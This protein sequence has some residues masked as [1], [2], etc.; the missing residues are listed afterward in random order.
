[1]VQLLYGLNDGEID[2]YI[3]NQ[4]TSENSLNELDDSMP[5]EDIIIDLSY[6]DIFSSLE[7][8]NS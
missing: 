2:N 1:M 4:I 8:Q 3:K 5:L 6:N 7:I